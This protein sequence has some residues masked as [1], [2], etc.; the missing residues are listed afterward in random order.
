M[1]QLRGDFRAGD[2]LDFDRVIIAGQ[3]GFAGHQKIGDGCI[4]FA[5]SGVNGDIEPGTQLFGYPAKPRM[6]THRENAYISKLEG[7]FKEVKE[8]KKK[9]TNLEET[10]EK[11]EK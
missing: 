3:V 9:L 10:K 11:R 8:L 5:K 4:I 6:Q 7:L 1:N 2:A